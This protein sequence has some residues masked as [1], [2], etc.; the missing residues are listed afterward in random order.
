MPSRKYL[1]GISCNLLNSLRVPPRR[2]QLL[3]LRPPLQLQ[4]QA[5]THWQKPMQGSCTSARKSNINFP[6]L[7][8]PVFSR[9]TDN[10]ELPDTAYVAILQNNAQFGQIT[11]GNS[12]KWVRA[13][14]H[15]QSQAICLHFFRTRLNHRMGCSTSPEAMSSRTLPKQTAKSF[16]A[17]TLHGKSS[18]LFNS[19][20]NSQQVQPVAGMDKYHPYN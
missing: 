18:T 17:T 11:P 1:F 16:E 7:Y 8:Q 15:F 6:F 4:A 19:L 12:M 13:L 10:P 9:A 3:R 20:T 2:R 14:W 5:S